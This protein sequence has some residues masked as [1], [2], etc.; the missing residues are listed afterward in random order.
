MLTFTNKMASTER[1]GTD[2]G[3]QCLHWNSFYFWP[4]HLAL[5]FAGSK[6][7]DTARIQISNMQTRHQDHLLS[8]DLSDFLPKCVTSRTNQ[9]FD[10]TKILVF[11]L[12]EVKTR[13][14]R[15]HDDADGSGKLRAQSLYL[16][17]KKPLVGKTLELVT[18]RH[19]LV[20]AVKRFVK[21]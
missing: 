10:R 13:H 8:Q 15:V 9:L 19:G 6:G 11:L 3:M 5:C 12:R 1:S 21:R 17:R 4:S 20:Y 2:E 16:H 18:P 7:S 14:F